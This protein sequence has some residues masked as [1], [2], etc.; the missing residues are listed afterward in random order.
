MDTAKPGGE[1]PGRTYADRASLNYGGNQFKKKVKLNILDI[2]LE[3]KDQNVSYN[4][5][6][7]ELSKLL[8]QR[9]KINPKNIIKID[10][11]GF[12]KILLELKSALKPEDFMNFPAFDIRDG[13]RT[14]LYK[15]HHKKEVL[16]TIS[17]LDLETP[18]DN[19]IHVLSFFGKVKSGIEY[20]KIKEE[21]GESAEAKLLNNILSGEH[22]IWIEVE[23]PIPSYG[24]INGRRV[25]IFYNGQKQTCA[26]CFK[27]K[28]SW[29][30]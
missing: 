25:K 24:V 27:F 22:K 26:R 9:M 23:K 7:D 15:P 13:L 2:I 4:L 16:V 6:K 18:D 29:I 20:S 3:R 30:F 11:S 5:T 14:K 17:W 28:E 19:V 12:G 10:T 8:F 1:P 21:P